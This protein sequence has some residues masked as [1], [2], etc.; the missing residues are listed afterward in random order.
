MLEQ[1]M[2]S[3]FQPRSPLRNTEEPSI[4]Q[5]RLQENGR[6][7][8]VEGVASISWPDRDLYVDV[9]DDDPNIVIKS[10]QN[11]E[12]EEIDVETR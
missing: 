8:L 11:G 7:E 6:A 2:N 4:V 5:R 3:S 12:W 9:F 10:F 1:N